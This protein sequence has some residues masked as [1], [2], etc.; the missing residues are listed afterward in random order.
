[1]KILKHKRYVQDMALE[2][3]AKIVQEACYENKIDKTKVELF[4]KY[5][6]RLKKLYKNNKF[7]DK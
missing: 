3:R 4:L 5:N 6:E 7:L 1:M 2:L